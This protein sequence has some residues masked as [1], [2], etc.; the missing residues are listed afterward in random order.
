MP[1][2]PWWVSLI[3]KFLIQ[4]G[5]SFVL[6]IFPKLADMIKSLPEEVKQLI[7]SL[8]KELENAPTKA[9]RKAVRKRYA[10]K[11]EGVGCPI[12]PQ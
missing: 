5:P 4:F 2:L 3:I 7:L 12:E 11:C 1:A 6:K 8:I 10:K 9:D